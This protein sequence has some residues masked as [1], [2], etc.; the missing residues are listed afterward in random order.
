MSEY[1]LSLQAEHW[2]A[3]THSRKMS[4][5][6]SRLILPPQ[7]V[8]KFNVDG[9]IFHDQPRVGVGIVLKDARG[10]RLS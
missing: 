3:Q 8:K 7:G 4:Q 6:Y 2:S 1:A 10:E 9:A 5:V